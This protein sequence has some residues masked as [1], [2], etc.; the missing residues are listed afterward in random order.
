MTYIIDADGLTDPQKRLLEAVV[1]ASPDGHVDSS[2]MEGFRLGTARAL[3]ARGF[4]SL[5][6]DQ[7][8]L[9][10]VARVVTAE[11]NMI[12]RLRDHNLTPIRVG[13]IVAYRT[14]FGSY[15]IGE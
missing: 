7:Q 1:Q 4:I 11:E 8:T 15:M 5:T 10:W 9:S 6:V 2:N 3:A 14:G 12:N 13:S